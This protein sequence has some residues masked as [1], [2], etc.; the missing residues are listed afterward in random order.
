MFAPSEKEHSLN[1]MQNSSKQE[2]LAVEHMKTKKKKKKHRV[3]FFQ[4]PSSIENRKCAL[5][6]IELRT[7]S[8]FL[9]FV[10]VK[11]SHQN[12]LTCI[13]Q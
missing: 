6:R 7:S 13:L 12:H 9:L 5:E 1:V 4:W 11:H 3:R 2:R 8:F 10:A